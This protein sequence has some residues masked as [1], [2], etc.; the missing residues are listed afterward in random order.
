MTVTALPATQCSPAEQLSSPCSGAHRLIPKCQSV[1]ALHAF[2]LLLF[3][4]AS[5]RNSLFS[6]TGPSPGLPTRRGSLRPLSAQRRGEQGCEHFIH[7][8][9]FTTQ[10]HTAS[11]WITLSF[12]GTSS[13]ASCTYIPAV[14]HKLYCAMF[15]YRDSP[16]H[17]SPSAEGAV[18][19]NFPPH[20]GPPRLPVF[21]QRLTCTEGRVL[22]LPSCEHYLRGSLLLQWDPLPTHLEML[23]DLFLLLPLP[24]VSQ[25]PF[26]F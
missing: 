14:T 7:P 9:P 16:F 13:T 24:A 3:L 17:T 4:P 23:P 18:R 15:I 21:T 25:S 19:G 10:P 20:T 6:Q 1:Y 12:L 2:L 5:P 26:L 11:L 8:S 22:N